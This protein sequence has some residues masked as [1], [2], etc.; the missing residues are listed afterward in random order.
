MPTVYKLPHEQHLQAQ[1][2]RHRD[3]LIPEPKVNPWQYSTRRSSYPADRTH[4]DWRD[5]Q[6]GY[7]TRLHQAAYLNDFT[8][9]RSLVETEAASPFVRDR[10][11]DSP[12][13]LAID[14][15]AALVAMYLADYMEHVYA[16]CHRYEQAT[17]HLL[18]LRSQRRRQLIPRGLGGRSSMQSYL[19]YQMTGGREF[20]DTAIR[21][22]VELRN[23][24]W[25]VNGPLIS[26]VRVR[27]SA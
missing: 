24:D 19:D 21:K 6:C 4:V 23:L 11:Q 13:V 26:A 16:E 8:K 2:E 10:R 14:W 1:I 25:K 15:G 18:G 17:G 9:V 7:R 22:Q 12:L 3:A 5:P 27:G 20:D